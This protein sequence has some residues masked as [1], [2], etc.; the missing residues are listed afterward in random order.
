MRLVTLKREERKAR[1]L[2]KDKKERSVTLGEAERSAIMPA[3]PTVGGMF[4]VS[5][6]GQSLSLSLSLSL[7]IYIYIYIYIL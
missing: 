2:A 7:S 6:S 1:K 4:Q 3:R 5:Y